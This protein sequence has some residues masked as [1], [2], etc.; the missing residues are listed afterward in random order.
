MSVNF[1]FVAACQVQFIQS[2]V[3]CCRPEF[4]PF[5]AL[6]ATVALPQVLSASMSGTV[7]VQVYSQGLSST[8]PCRS[9]PY[10]AAID[11]ALGVVVAI[12]SCSALMC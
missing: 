3:L 11:L 12:R 6:A 8:R 1:L 5:D 4:G 2:A 7:V 9:L 10:Q